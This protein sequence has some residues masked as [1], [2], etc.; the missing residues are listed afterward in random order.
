MTADEFATSVRKGD[1]KFRV[2]RIVLKAEGQTIRG[3]GLMSIVGDDFHI[4]LEVPQ[5]YKVPQPKREIWKPAD[6]WKLSGMIEGDLRFSSESVSPLGNSP[7][8][9]FGKKP[10]FVQYL[11]LDKINL[12]PEGFEAL[13]RRKRD[14]L[15]QQSPR[16]KAKYPDVEFH[17]VLFECV[18]TFLN[19]GTST[20]VKNDFLG[21]CGGGDSLDTFID[22]GL[23]YDFALIKK[24]GDLHVHFRSK[25]RF[26]SAAQD[27]DLRRFQAFLMGV[28][29]THGFQPWPYRIK[30]WRE[31]QK[32]ADQFR[33][34]HKLTKIS[35]APFDRGT[36]FH[37]NLRRKGARNSPVRL[38]ANFFEKQT[39]LSVELSRL[40][41]L[42]RE[43]G[44]ASF[45]TKTLALCSL[46]EGA[47]AL[48]FEG[49]KLEEEL[50]CS[51]PQFQE[52]IT[53]RDRL[54]KRLRALAKKGGH[55]SLNR[56]AGALS[57]AKEF[58]VQDKFKAI[59]QHFGL[60]YE[61]EMQKHLEAWSR[62]RNLFMHGNWKEEDSDFSDQS[63][64][65]G[66]INIFILK[67][68]GYSGQMKFN[69]FAQDAK[70]RYKTI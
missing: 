53:L 2:S 57:S 68:M 12:A 19:A 31:G 52:Y 38:A 35:Y 32:V 9:H 34:P 25:S 60:S 22:R 23:A 4:S 45:H 18:P 39:P 8:W 62:K 17:A 30:F 55:Q 33:P 44:S 11:S 47:V 69:A 20:R 56:I 36:R 5:R 61:N 42:F 6:A 24:E 27:D 7:S 50:R 13:S 29:F 46:F 58:R 67:L 65:A 15:L 41:F 40:L 1:A 26:R 70:D 10:K 66:G 63:L 28:G 48:I 21:I 64:M 59:C 3:Q 49:L 14:K 43:T 37:G 54:H 16:K 51:D